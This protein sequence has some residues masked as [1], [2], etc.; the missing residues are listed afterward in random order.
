MKTAFDSGEPP[1]P[2]RTKSGDDDADATKIASL[3]KCDVMLDALG[4]KYT[5]TAFFQAVL[6]HSEMVIS[7][8][9]ECLRKIQVGIV[10]PI[11]QFKCPVQAKNAAGVTIS[12][13]LG[14]NCPDESR[15]RICTVRCTDQLFGGKENLEKYFIFNCRVE[16][17]IDPKTG[18]CAVCAPW[19]ACFLGEVYE[20]MCIHAYE[21]GAKM[22]FISV[23][24]TSTGIESALGKYYLENKFHPDG[25]PYFEDSQY[26]PN[27]YHLSLLGYY[28]DKMG[29]VEDQVRVTMLL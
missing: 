13:A 8:A 12:L 5:G 29:E 11:L 1:T 19:E 15:W 26:L 27:G 16:C 18:R 23:A 21:I 20:V 25:S 7:Y 9:K 4:V 28:C 22:T 17:R 14:G 6:P 24:G 2:K 3:V 10:N